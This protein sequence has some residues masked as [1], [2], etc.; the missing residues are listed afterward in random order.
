[1]ENVPLKNA[2]DVLTASQYNNLTRSELLNVVLGAGIA[3]EELDQNQ[4][5]KAIIDLTVPVGTVRKRI[6]DGPPATHGLLGVTW[7]LLTDAEGHVAVGASSEGVWA[8]APGESGGTL[9]ETTATTSLTEEQAGLH[10]HLAPFSTFISSNETA[11]LFGKTPTI[12]GSLF[13]SPLDFFETFREPIYPKTGVSGSGTPHSHPLPNLRRF[14]INF[15]RRV[16]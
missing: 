5:T 9:D 16:T 15:W 2:T 1:M 4:L 8:V 14:G 10:F 11:S 3:P 6:I 13:T 7:E 12:H